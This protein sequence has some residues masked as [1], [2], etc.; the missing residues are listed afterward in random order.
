[1][2]LDRVGLTEGGP[3][4]LAQGASSLLRLGLAD[5]QPGGSSGRHHAQV[6]A[7]RFL[8]LGAHPLGDEGAAVG[9]MAV[10]DG[11]AGACCHPLGGGPMPR[12]RVPAALAAALFVLPARAQVAPEPVE[13]GAP[14]SATLTRD[15]PRDSEMQTHYRLYAY[16]AVAGE[17]IVATLRSKDFSP[18]LLVG[19]ALDPVRDRR[20]PGGARHELTAVKESD[21]GPRPGASETEGAEIDFTFPTAGTYY[22]MVNAYGK[23]ETGAY[24]LEEASSVDRTG[25]PEVLPIAPGDAVSGALPPV[26]RTGPLAS[27]GGPHAVYQLAGAACERLRI[28]VRAP[29]FHPKV[30]IGPGDSAASFAERSSA[31]APE[32]ASVEYTLP[33]E[34]PYWIVLYD[35]QRRGKMAFDL[36]VERVPSG[37]VATGERARAGGLDTPG[38]REL[39]TGGTLASDFPATPPRGAVWERFWFWGN[40]GTRREVTATSSAFDPKVFVDGPTVCVPAPDLDVGKQE[41][42]GTE[43]G[44]GGTHTRVVDLPATGWYRVTVNEAF[45]G[46]GKGG[47]YT[48]GVSGETPS[49]ADAF[50]AAAAPAPAAK[51][52]T[53]PPGST[54]LPDGLVYVRNGEAIRRNIRFYES[55]R[56]QSESGL[57][58][59]YR[60]EDVWYWAQAGEEVDF[61]ARSQDLGLDIVVSGPARG[62]PAPDTELPVVRERD[63]TGH[64]YL[65]VGSFV[66]FP[67]T[68]WYRVRVYTGTGDSGWF[69]LSATPRGVELPESAFGP[70]F[71][72]PAPAPVSMSRFQTEAPREPA[73]LDEMVAEHVRVNEAQGH[74]LRIV[75]DYQALRSSSFFVDVGPPVQPGAFRFVVLE[76][77]GLAAATLNVHQQAYRRGEWHKDRTLGLPSVS[78]DRPGGVKLTGARFVVNADFPRDERLVFEV[79]AGAGPGA[80]ARRVVVLVF[81]E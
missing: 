31:E 8:P 71:G 51:K 5:N 68:G 1:M 25:G 6:P 11:S 3:G 26:P 39:P 67:E 24:V 53:G 38:L 74:T 60:Y 69:G 79:N 21:L 75:E 18:Y 9:R 7:L 70:E 77:G 22:L 40:A 49:P 64:R 16:E 37:G 19:S 33:R 34:G 12:L 42:R 13:A 66:T 43:R 4:R 36:R 27:V 56:V 17:R 29:G 72:P 14:V 30:L 52:D 47:P 10:L 32:E 78:E 63:S 65:V 81:K 20:A 57:R 61:W 54:P 44:R 50:A 46:P 15:D 2:R 41:V 76:A 45:G 48:L 28:T 55:P 62:A 35:E 73:T 58:A 80:S 23:G 59:R